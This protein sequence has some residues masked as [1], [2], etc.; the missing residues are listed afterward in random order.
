MSKSD[1]EC[2]K[3]KWNKKSVKH[4]TSP[5]VQLNLSIR[6]KRNMAHSSSQNDC[7]RW[8][9]EKGKTA[10]H[11]WLCWKCFK[12]Q[13]LRFVCVL[14]QSKLY[15]NKRPT[16]NKIQLEGVNTFFC[17]CIFSSHLHFVY[18][19]F[20]ATLNKSHDWKICQ[21]A[22]GLW[23]FLSFNHSPLRKHRVM[24]KRNIQQKQA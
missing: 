24:M 7:A 17:H 13:Q 2:K 12:L 5:A 20:C 18:F 19:R 10:G 1:D 9:L 6:N 16:H 22:K 21:Q 8:K 4:R 15:D 14:H 11:L 3:I 23:K